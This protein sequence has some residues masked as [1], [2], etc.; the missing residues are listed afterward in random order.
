MSYQSD[1]K[2]DYPVTNGYYRTPLGP[3]AIIYSSSADCWWTNKP[4]ELAGV[5]E[6]IV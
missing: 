5:K 2:H 3:L 4:L 6:S 1:S